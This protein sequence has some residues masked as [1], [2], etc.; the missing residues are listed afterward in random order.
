MKIAAVG[1]L[2]LSAL[3][4][5]MACNANANIYTVNG[6]NGSINI[7][8][9]VEF[10]LN[11]KQT[12]SI[13]DS[14][15]KDEYDQTGRALLELSGERNINNSYYIKMKSQLLMGTAGS[16]NV[17]D[18][19]M[20][21]GQKGDWDLRVG[22]FEAFDLFPVGQD[23][24]LEYSGDTANDLYQ[25]NAGYVYQLKE[26]RGR[27]ADAGQLMYSQSF[28]NLYIEIAAMMGDRTDLFSGDTYHGK[29]ISVG[30]KDSFL[31]RPVISYQVNNFRFSTGIETNLASD[32]I[33]DS[34]GKDVGD[35]TGYGAT[36]NYSSNDLSVNVNYAYLDALDETNTSYGANILFKGF[37]LGYVEGNSDIDSPGFCEG[38][39]TVS[40][41]YSS[42]Q[43]KDVLD[44]DD[45]SIY[46]GAFYTMMDK[47]GT[48]VGSFV[49]SDDS[50]ARLRLKYYF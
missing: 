48:D 44:V 45:F 17:D 13:D 36:V 27:G 47:S 37:G 39:I 18:A 38:D 4:V 42:Y 20:S 16:A 8:G 43:F 41:V 3:L 12:D 7:S 29:A 15:D 24:F 11:Y 33:V 9:D 30:D 49:E 19:W 2:S 50:G 34:D 14:K 22:R 28:S 40:T 10:D 25:D 5:S 31:I 21:I 23:T 1:K 35:R 26:A 46:V 6:D 32:T